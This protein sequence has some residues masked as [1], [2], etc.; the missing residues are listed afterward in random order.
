MMGRWKSLDEAV[1][2]IERTSGTATVEEPLADELVVKLHMACAYEVSHHD[3]HYQ[4]CG[5]GRRIIRKTR[6]D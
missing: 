1:E 4:K 6:R 3:V 5:G 2:H